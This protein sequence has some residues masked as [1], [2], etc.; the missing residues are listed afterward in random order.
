M[1][2]E[3]ALSYAE[4]KD[5]PKHTISGSLDLLLYQIQSQE[6]LALILRSAEAFHVSR[7][8]L[9]QPLFEWDAKKIR[10]ISRSTAQKRAIQS[11]DNLDEFSSLIKEYDECLAL[12]WTNQSSDLYS[13][14]T[15]RN[16][17]LMIVGNERNGVPEDILKYTQQSVHIPI[18]GS[19]SSINVACAT[20]IAL[21]HFFNIRA[22][23]AGDS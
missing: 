10:R 18:S 1:K 3:H 8:F 23:P 9:F 11:I 4:W 13:K 2:N 22:S 12:E 6:N 14:T 5:T 7:I 19:Q 16:S 20:S 21:S 17:S 15:L